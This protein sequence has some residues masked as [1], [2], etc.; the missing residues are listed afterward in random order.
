MI[1]GTTGFLGGVNIA[2]RYYD[3]EILKSGGTLM[4]KFPGV[5]SGTSVKFSSDRYFI[6]KQQFKRKRKYFP[7]INQMNIKLDEK[8]A[9]FYSQIITSGPDSDWASIMQCYFL[10]ISNAK[11]MYS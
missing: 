8:S 5:C 2:D 7:S 11:R 10:A 6:I 9:R 1:D 3:G 4:L